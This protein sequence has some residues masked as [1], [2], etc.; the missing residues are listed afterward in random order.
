MWETGK[1]YILIFYRIT[2]D[3]IL[4][5]FLLIFFSVC[6]NVHRHAF[7]LLVTNKD[8]VMFF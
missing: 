5:Y 8:H 7:D 3:I 4:I 2:V 1:K 6:L